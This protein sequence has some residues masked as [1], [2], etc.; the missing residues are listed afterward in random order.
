MKPTTFC[1]RAWNVKAGRY[2]H[3][4]PGRWLAFGAKRL[5][6]AVGVRPRANYADPRLPFPALTGAK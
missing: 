1:K 2:V 6:G 4:K 5:T 3:A